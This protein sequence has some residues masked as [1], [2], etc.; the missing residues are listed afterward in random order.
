MNGEAEAKQALS[1]V[2]GEFREK[3]PFKPESERAAATAS[4]MAK[5]T[6]LPKKRVGSPIPCTG[7]KNQQRTKYNRKL[8]D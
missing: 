6:E 2:A 4:L 8:K 1:G 7:D 3:G 5:N